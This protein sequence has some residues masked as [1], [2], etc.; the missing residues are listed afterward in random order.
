M[1]AFLPYKLMKS[2]LNYVK[3]G[4]VILISLLSQ[5]NLKTV[6]AQALQKLTMKRIDE[7]PQAIERE[8]AVIYIRSVVPDIF[9]ISTNPNWTFRKVAGKDGEYVMRINPNEAYV[10]GF[11][12]K[13][14]LSTV[15]QR[16][17]L[18]LREV[19]VWEVIAEKSDIVIDE[20]F[21]KLV[22][23]GTP[24]G[25]TI[26]L[27]YIATAS[28]VP[29]TFERIK[30]GLHTIRI[31]SNNVYSDPE[32][33]QIAI[34]ANKTAELKVEERLIKATLI[35]D[36][37]KVNTIHINGNRLFQAGQLN[38]TNYPY[39]FRQTRTFFAVDVPAKQKP[40]IE[41]DEPNYPMYKDSLEVT[42]GDTI[43]VNPNRA[44]LILDQSLA[45]TIWI[46]GKILKT[47]GS[48]V[49]G[50]P[51]K[52]SNFGANLSIEL[53]SLL[54]VT[55]K[56]EKNYH[57]TVEDSYTFEK[58]QRLEVTRYPIP[59]NAYI[60][61][62]TPTDSVNVLLADNN[63]AISDKETL[64]YKPV[65]Y[66]NTSLTIP[67]GDYVFKFEKLGYKTVFFEQIIQPSS[68]NRV[69]TYPIQIKKQGGFSFG[70]LLLWTAVL[71]GGGYAAYWYFT[72][73][74]GG[75]GTE[76]LIPFPNPPD[77]PTGVNR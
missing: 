69:R 68:D 17:V 38:P 1:F 44:Y 8:K 73:D 20:G 33:Y 43:Q 10:L 32:T 75:S 24:E 31:L 65:G 7:A 39:D 25:G 34:Q 58:G 29:F 53:S 45:N 63:K 42:P 57:Q 15:Q 16:M 47:N 14:F 37:Y 51:Y 71:G 64:I 2:R 46:N 36:S 48:L 40:Y 55:V 3:F 66:S 4:L 26:E 61:F 77:W 67:S 41:I 18:K 6:S 5:F 70:K 74:G 54:P 52:Y 12:A 35:V 23:S 28:K 56:M 11:G 13:G 76:P 72:Q 19:Q 62:E 59:Q 30:S 21:G 49:T 60:Y 27:D 50:F 9:P 22:I